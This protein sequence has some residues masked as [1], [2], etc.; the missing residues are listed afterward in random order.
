MEGQPG[1][2]APVK[3]IPSQASALPA[4]SPSPAPR[5]PP[6]PSPQ[7]ALPNAA[8]QKRH[9]EQKGK[10]VADTSKSRPTRE[11]DAQRAAKQ[12]KIK[13]QTTR[14]QEKSDSQHPEPQ[15]WLPVP[16]HSREPLR[17]DASIKDFNGGIRCH[18]ASAIEEAL[19]L[20]KDIAEIKNMR[21]NELVLDNKR[22]LGMVRS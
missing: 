7:P 4:R 8:E 18:I 10:E 21:K 11:E 16:M 5:Q 22:Y 3:S 6:R 2:S 17:D 12:Q 14:G 13:H 9:R 15:A 19:L 1:K 20:R